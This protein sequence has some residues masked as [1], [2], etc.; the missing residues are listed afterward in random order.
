MICDGIHLHDDIVKLLVRCKGVSR[1]VAI[2]DAMEAAGMPDGEYSLGGQAVYVKGG[3]ARLADGTLAGSV[4]TMK[5]ALY[6]LI[7]VYGIA[8]EE[9]CAMCTSTPAA[10]IGETKAG[11]VAPGCPGILTRW[12]PDWQMKSVITITGE[13][14]QE[15]R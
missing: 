11:Y 6:R 8:P 15:C 9:A 7:H 14:C 3:A 2:T 1:A 13:S 5:H 4:L 12:S 10:S